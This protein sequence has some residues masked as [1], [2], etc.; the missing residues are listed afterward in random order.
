[1]GFQVQID[2]TA[3]QGG[4]GLRRDSSQQRMQLQRFRAARHSPRSQPRFMKN[5]PAAQ[6]DGLLQAAGRRKTT[7]QTS[8]PLRKEGCS[9]VFFE[10]Q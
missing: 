2:E 10:L 6:G 4:G 7:E 3:E 8:V 5:L 1:M 9:N